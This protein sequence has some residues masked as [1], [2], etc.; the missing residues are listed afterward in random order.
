[1]SLAS[2]PETHVTIVNGE[3]FADGFHEGIRVA[4]EILRDHLAHAMKGGAP[5]IFKE[6]LESW[7]KDIAGAQFKSGSKGGKA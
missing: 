5:D 7:I 3:T 4:V 1:M 2:K 6:I